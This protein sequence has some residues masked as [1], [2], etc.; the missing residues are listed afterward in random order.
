MLK[1]FAMMG[2]GCDKDGAVYV[3]DMDSIEKSNLNRQFLFRPDDLRVR[4][5]RLIFFFYW[6]FCSL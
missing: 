4:L 3:T 5:L 1:N 2:M 6:I